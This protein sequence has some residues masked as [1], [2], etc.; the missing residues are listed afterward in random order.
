L[1]CDILSV[2]GKKRY[3]PETCCFVPKSVNLLF[4][5]KS[6]KRDLPQ[7]VYLVKSGKYKAKIMINSKNRSLGTF[8]TPEA[9]AEVYNIAKARRIVAVAIQQ[10]DSHI[11]AGLIKH[12]AFQKYGVRETWALYAVAA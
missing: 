7:G 8:T 4:G 10:K 12:A 5:N 6:A 1:D 3:S 9:A 2:D 11:A